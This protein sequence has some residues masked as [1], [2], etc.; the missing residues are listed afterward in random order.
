MSLVYEEDIEKSPLTAYHKVCNY[1][2]IEEQNP[3]INL[4]KDNIYKL[5]E[6]IENFDELENYLKNTKYEWM[7]YE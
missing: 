6:V 4:K 3:E 1:L 2:K 7:L 5:N